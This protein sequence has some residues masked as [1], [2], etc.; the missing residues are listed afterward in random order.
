MVESSPRGQAGALLGT[1]IAAPFS[2]PSDLLAYALSL[3]DLVVLTVVMAVVHVT[4]LS[5]AFDDVP[6]FMDGLRLGFVIAAVFVGTQ[7]IRGAYDP[8]VYIRTKSQVKGVLLA[9]ALAFLVLAWFAFL[10]KIT[11]DF[12]RAS[13][14]MNFVIGLAAIVSVR[15]SL[16]QLIRGLIARGTLVLRRAF[17]VFSGED[18]SPATLKRL[19]DDGIWLAGSTRLDHSPEGSN[20]DHVVARIREQLHLAPFEEVYVFAQW[21]NPEMLRSLSL[22]LSALPLSVFLIADNHTQQ[23]VRSRSLRTGSLCGFEVQ[24]APLTSSEV[25]Q[26]RVLD[27]VLASVALIM[28]APLL[29]IVSL[30]IAAEGGGPVIFR[31]R[32]RGLGGR[33]FTILKFRSMRVCEDGGHIEQAKRGD[34]RITKLGRILR[35]TSI[36]ELPQLI[37]VLKGEMSIV[38]PRPH[39]LAHDTHYDELIEIYQYRHH[40]PPG[41]TGWAQIHG[42]RGE[43]AELRL[44]EKRVEHD[45]WYINHWS[46]FLDIW[47]IIRT[48]FSLVSTKNAY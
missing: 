8:S 33:L 15:L 30:A 28:L 18:A 20:V 46:I 40:L 42:F 9:W 29:T 27:I 3:V 41:L 35:R 12:S 13:L 6:S 45:L 7:Y 34:P 1:G 4:Y 31:Q 17:A 24:R 16:S 2:I 23:I 39:A 36:D 21:N 37:N 11:D 14:S 44:M 19:S 22:A 47:I 25:L 43:T 5:V 38:G 32:R 10:M 26:K 48:A